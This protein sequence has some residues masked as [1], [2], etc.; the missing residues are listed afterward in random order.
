MPAQT[1]IET[2]EFAPG[3]EWLREVAGK[4]QGEDG[5]PVEITVREFL[6][7]FNSSRRGKNVVANIRRLLKEANVRTEP[8]FEN[9]HFDSPVSM[10]LIPPT[11]AKP[12]NSDA[13]TN[14]DLDDDSQAEATRRISSLDA[15]SRKPRSVTPDADLMEATTIMAMNDY[16]QLP[17]MKN[18]KTV[19]GIVSWKSIGNGLLLVSNP[20][21]RRVRDYMEPA[22]LVSAS[23][24][25]LKAMSIMASTD[26]VL[27]QDR[28]N[29]I[30]GIITSSDLSK[31][32]N[33]LAA[34]F[35]LIEEIESYLRILLER[36]FN[37]PDVIQWT[38]NDSSPS[39]DNRRIQSIQ[40]L[41]LGD[42]SRFLSDPEN[43]QQLDL[44]VHQREFVKR[45][46]SVR[47]IRNKVMHFRSDGT[48]E[49]VRA[50]QDFARFFRDLKSIG[51]VK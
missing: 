28:R 51:A 44:L 48:D 16:S 3:R 40:D 2:D 42:Y 41:S 13:D 21:P 18:K 20:E 22:I 10:E 31:E 5:T 14:L 23:D 32:F 27:V 9:F 11:R 39:Q 30:T 49:D 45:L 36:S 29:D 15:A 37:P 34:P 19:A 17:V 33:Q 4:L 46:E 25:L 6:A 12:A 50:L 35:L 38:R 8:D 24:P 7:K 26:C 43:W 1:T 47:E